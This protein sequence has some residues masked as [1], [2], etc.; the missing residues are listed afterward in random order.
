M[1]YYKNSKVQALLFLLS[2]QRYKPEHM[3]TLCSAGITWK[4]C[5]Y[6]QVPFLFCSCRGLGSYSSFVVTPPASTGLS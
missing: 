1:C 4:L 2:L 5:R 3:E 6:K